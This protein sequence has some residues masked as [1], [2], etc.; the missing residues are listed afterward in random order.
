MKVS[1]IIPTRDSKNIPAITK[2]L[3]AY[4]S[5]AD[6][7]SIVVGNQ[8]SI[9]TAHE[10]GFRFFNS[11]D[12]DD[13]FIICHDDIILG[14]D[15]IKFRE[16][17][18]Q[19]LSQR[20]VGFVGPAGTSFLGKEAIWWDQEVWRMGLHSGQVKHIDQAGKEYTTTYGPPNRVVVLDG[21]FLAATKRTLDLVGFKKPSYFEGDW[22]FY[23]IHYTTTAH[24]LGL[25]NHTIHMDI[26]HQSR[27]E[28]V[29][30]DSWHKNREAYIKNTKLPLKL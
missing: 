19:S 14:G 27:G 17:L 28:L 5:R 10:R 11:S 30:R 26:V 22:D 13:I 7:G 1:A 4:L 9:F 3:V 20:G 2:N 23:D 15:P 18:E 25:E 21:L 24:L 8:D 29:G 12:P 6:I 16:T